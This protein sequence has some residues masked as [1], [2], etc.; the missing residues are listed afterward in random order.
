MKA[1][2]V[3]HKAAPEDAPWF[4]KFGCKDY[5]YVSG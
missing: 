5:A 4:N 2:I 3:L 1:G